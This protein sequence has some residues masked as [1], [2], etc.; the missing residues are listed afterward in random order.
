MKRAIYAA[1]T[2]A[3]LTG[4]GQSGKPPQAR[5]E[6]DASLQLPAGDAVTDDNL[7]AYAKAKGDYTPRDQFDKSFDDGPLDG[8]RFLITR[9]L[10][11]PG[12][13][14]TVTY[15]WSY[16]PQAELLKF[17]VDPSPSASSSGGSA[18]NQGLEIF[19]DEKLGQPRP[20]SNAYGV[21][22]QVSPRTEL[23]VA[24]GALHGENMGVLPV[25]HT[26]DFMKDRVLYTKLHKEVKLPPD[27]ARAATATLRAEISGVVR[28]AASGHTIECSDLHISATLG[29]P[30]EED[31]RKC[32]INV[33]ISR[34]AFSSKVG[35][36][37]E[38]K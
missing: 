1:V 4:C 26:Y 37:A 16:D 13:F 22:K 34:I 2:L 11:G 23:S 14:T 8:R 17:D 18:P 6:P 31:V 29:S 5:V 21:T 30:T 12:A 25:D 35:A 19:R 3:L 33:K 36:L 27:Q 24:V 15:M 20:E 32:V 7:V 28:K 10:F 38:W 9:P